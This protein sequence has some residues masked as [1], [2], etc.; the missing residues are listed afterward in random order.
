[1]NGLKATKTLVVEN[2]KI[3]DNTFYFIYQPNFDDENYKHVL[4]RTFHKEQISGSMSIMYGGEKGSSLKNSESKRVAKST[5]YNRSFPFL[6]TQV[7]L[8]T[9]SL[10]VQSSKNNIYRV[11]WDKYQGNTMLD[12]NFY[13]QPI[14]IQSR[15]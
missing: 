12:P 5:K 15:S 11:F 6:V 1:M 2:L 3:Q 4:E 9:S 13:N 7:P 14:T 8:D 10:E